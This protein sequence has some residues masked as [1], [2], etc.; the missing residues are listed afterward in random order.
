MNGQEKK[1]EKPKE[2]S[3]SSA[4]GNDLLRMGMQIKGENNSFNDI[5]TKKNPD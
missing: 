4:I 5:A 2:R 1:G 3:K